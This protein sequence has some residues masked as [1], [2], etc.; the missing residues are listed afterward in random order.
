MKCMKK[1]IAVVLAAVMAMTLLTACG[2]GGSSGASNGIVDKGDELTKAINAELKKQGSDIQVTYD[3]ETT[4]KLATACY[5]YANWLKDNPDSTEDQKDE[6]ENKA[7]ESLEIKGRYLNGK[8]TFDGTESALQ[9]IAISIATRIKK[10]EDTHNTHY[11]KIGYATLVDATGRPCEM[12]YLA[13][14]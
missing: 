3:K 2:G 9:S 14:Q 11:Q 6:A 8:R 7:F 5:K 13:V 1:L 12:W 10:S 4:E